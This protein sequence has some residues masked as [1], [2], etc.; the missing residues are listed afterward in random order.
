M[1][2]VQAKIINSRWDSLP[3]N[4]REFI[5][6]EENSI[7]LE[8]L[9]KREL[10]PESKLADFQK[11][12]GYAV[13]GLIKLESLEVEIESSLNV[14][15]QTAKN[16]TELVKQELFSGISD[17]IKKQYKPLSESDFGL[18]PD[19]REEIR[20]TPP[21]PPS[22]PANSA[23]TIQKTPFVM[24]VNRQAPTKTPIANPQISKKIA[25]PIP[26]PASHSSYIPK[27]SNTPAAGAPIPPRT[28]NLPGGG[29]P[30]S[31]G[32]VVIQSTPESRPIQPPQ[33][34]RL[35]AAAPGTQ[36]IPI[37]RPPQVRPSRVELG[38]RTSFLP[39]ETLG[40]HSSNEI[41][42]A[43]IRFSSP[44]NIYMPL[45]GAL[46]SP[47]TPQNQPPNPPAPPEPNN[48]VPPPQY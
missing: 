37:P 13:L 39:N 12:C 43:P 1:I 45:D 28:V 32:P 29:F 30:Q 15:H 33:N 5:T 18:V 6:A 22:L 4:L 42:R 7:K 48:L 9:A 10:V 47:S 24:E 21:T 36:R 17:Q 8:S 23:P 46:K 34:F 44:K 25:P 19:R 26:R 2:K 38:G 20:P 40:E 35:G 3:E 16:L 41:V 31:R 14:P 27:P 11:I